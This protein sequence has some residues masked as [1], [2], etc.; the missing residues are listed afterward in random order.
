[1]SAWPVVLAVAVA[2]ACGGAAAG[3]MSPLAQY[4]DDRDAA[5]ECRDDAVLVL[6]AADMTPAC[7]SENTV[8]V[9]IERGWAVAAPSETNT[10]AKSPPEPRTE[11]SISG[12]IVIGSILP[13]TG[14]LAS[15]GEENME[16]A[17]LGVADFNRYLEERGEQWRLKLAGEDSATDPVTALEELAA[18]NARDIDIVI[19]PGTS[20]SV[21]DM[22]GY[23]DANGMMLVSCCSA[24]PGLAI[25]GDG[26]FRFVGNDEH[27]GAVLAALA[28]DAGIET[29]VPIYRG[30]AWGNG[31][32]ADVKESFDGTV[33][34]GMRYNA[35]IPE[36]SAS[37]SILA[38]RVGELVDEAGADKVAVLLVSFAEGLQILQY[39][40]GHPELARVQWYG[41]AMN[42][43]SKSGS[44]SSPELARVQWYGSDDDLQSLQITGD[45]IAG[46]FADS[47]SFSVPV[48]SVADNETNAHVD[49]R[50]SDLLGR[51]PATYAYGSYDAA[52]VVGKA[53]LQAQSASASDIEPIFIDV[54]NSHSGALGNIRLNEAG[55]L[56]VAHYEIWTV[57]GGGWIPTAKYSN[58]TGELSD[59]SG[60]H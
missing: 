56:D 3:A 60:G 40:A 21:R 47:V 6:K 18:L 41:S 14:E 2:A 53:M 5:I 35:E 12:Q 9:L 43:L 23:S 30:D 28:Q 4:A 46:E 52:W 34:A 48:I 1:M 7:V 32:V 27:H 10:P 37:A 29:L 44:A 25:E 42:A 54:A 50:L 19:G 15:R 31:L 38:E 57:S 45:P 11:A 22:A 33:D 36:Y 8:Q 16:A 49:R 59:Y 26:V 39:S 55:D 20:S 24:A 58:S 17:K 13:L 51:V